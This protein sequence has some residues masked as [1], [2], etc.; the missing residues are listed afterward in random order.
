MRG[1]SGVPHDNKKNNTWKNR[2]R[3]KRKKKGYEKIVVIDQY[4]RKKACVYEK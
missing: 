2:E 1:K 4:G 3:V